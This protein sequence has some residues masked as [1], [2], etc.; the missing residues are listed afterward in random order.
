MNAPAKPRILIV[1]D[2]QH[3]LHVLGGAL[4]ELYQV[5]VATS[6]AQALK[7]LANP[8]LPDMVLLD[9]V[10]PD[11]D[12]FEVCRRLKAQPDTA[13][14]P[15]IFITA[16]DAE[17]DEARGFDLGAVDF[18]AK[19]IRPA[20]V[21]A[22]V[23]T[24]LTLQARTRELLKS[25]ELLRATLEST[26]DGILAVGRDGA[27]THAN[28]NF[29]R[30]FHLSPHS[31]SPEVQ[32]RLLARVAAQMEQPQAFLERL[33]HP[34]PAGATD[35]DVLHCKDGRILECCA[36]PLLLDGQV[37]GQVWNFANVTRQKLHEAQL[38]QAR[39]EAEAANKAKSTFLATMS[40]E[41]RTPL[42][43]VLGMA[44]LLLDLDLP[45]TG[46]DYAQTI[47]T[48]GNALLAIINDVLD[49]SKIEAEKLQLEA[50]PFNLHHLLQDLSLLFKGFAGKKAIDF[51]LGLDARLPDWIVGDPT[52]LR[53]ILVNLLSNAVKFTRKGRVTL[54]A[55]PLT[56]AN[57]GRALEKPF[58][59]RADGLVVRF[60]VLDTG[61]G[62]SPEQFSKL[63]KSFEQADSSTTRRYGG[64]GLGL[65]IT[66]KLVHLMQ[67]EIDVESTLG[68]GTLFRVVLP[69]RPGT[70]PEEALPG[71]E[72]PAG[73]AMPPRGARILVAEDDP[74]N[75]A[76][77]RGMLK[78]YELTVDYAENGRQA[79]ALLSRKA[80]DLV[81]MDCQ[82]PEMDG[83]AACQ[84]FRRLEGPQRHVPI[85]ALTAFAMQGDREK[86]LAAGMD[87]HL[88]KPVTRHGVQSALLRW[89]TPEIPPAVTP[90]PGDAL[91]AVPVPPVL[92]RQV[93]R[94]L[95]QEL[96]EDFDAVL[97]QFLELLPRRVQALRAA[98]ESR[99]PD[100]LA[101]EA[102]SLRG[103]SGQ[104][105][106]KRLCQYA[107]ALETLA[108]RGSLDDAAA[109]L[110]TLE[111]EQVRFADALTAAQRLT[112]FRQD[113]GQEAF[114]DFIGMAIRSLTGLLERIRQEAAGPAP[115]QASEA[116]LELAGLAGSYG[117]TEVERRA[118]AFATARTDQ[119]PSF[120]APLLEALVGAV[121]AARILLEELGGE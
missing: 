31:L 54:E 39:R 19:P 63:F 78:R 68:V 18:I 12:G 77:L 23:L 96:E 82:M 16:M 100:L 52:R 55:T 91:A 93:F 48:S 33:A 66:R 107:L 14:M 15:V 57:Q 105:G 73:M 72:P 90:T 89:L 30:L 103:S 44:E 6:G 120:P 99:R 25:G 88:P 1:D 85:V 98:L 112:A 74:I 45:P 29:L 4:K 79:V 46:R 118:A 86:C 111:E 115:R 116:A 56:D 36:V 113:L 10:M 110:A 114:R 104:F 62:I 59:Q 101:R 27:V 37:T 43:G 71:T 7:Q 106:G 50:I 28:A 87:D 3:N 121:G 40:H 35:C 75:R 49:Y 60:E 76:V 65:A 94:T 80:Y 51:E 17:A 108:Q 34:R 20:I 81:F 97:A 119:P 32:D 22:R 5:F 26:R 53:Q 11:I 47:L 102:H 24:H 2:E 21:R 67:G 9:I 8:P 42:N 64:T 84:A 69:V 58:Y 38:L 117:L 70:A 13:E 83:Y 95:H 109:W 92:D 41:I 61:V